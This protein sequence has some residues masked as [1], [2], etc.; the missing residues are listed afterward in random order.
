LAKSSCC[1]TTTIINT[2]K[3]D[4]NGINI[5]TYKGPLLL[6]CHFEN[7]YTCDDSEIGADF[8]TS[9]T[10]GRFGQAVLINGLD[11]LNYPSSGNINKNQGTIEFWIK[12]N[13]WDYENDKVDRTFFYINGSGNSENESL[14][15]S[16][17][18]SD[19]V[20]H[21]D[22]DT[23]PY[24]GA[25]RVWD[26]QKFNDELY[27]GIDIL[28]TVWK[29][30][31]TTDIWQVVT[32]LKNIDNDADAI[33]NLEVYDNQIWAATIN[34]GLNTQGIYNST[35]GINWSQNIEWSGLGTS[36]VWELQADGDYLFAMLS[37]HDI[38][39][40]AIL[41][42]YNGSD[43]EQ[44]FDFTSQG[45][46]RLFDLKRYNDTGGLSQLYLATG[47]GR[48]SGGV[49]CYIYNSSSNGTTWDVFK[50][51]SN[52]FNENCESVADLIVF[53]NN[54]FAVVNNGS[55]SDIGGGSIWEYDG[56]TWFHRINY[57][58]VFNSFHE[59][60]G[61]LY[62]SAWIDNIA[63]S[64]ELWKS[65]NGVDW[66]IVAD[67]IES[68]CDQIDEISSFQDRVYLGTHKGTEIHRS[69]EVGKGAG[70]TTFFTITDTK[71][72]T[73]RVKHEYDYTNKFTHI[74]TKWNLD[75]NGNNQMSLY[76]DNVL[77]DSIPNNNPA[78]SF[79]TLAD[80]MYIGSDNLG[81]NQA[82]AI[83]DELRIYNIQ[84]SEDE[85]NITY[86]SEIG[87]YYANITD[88]TDGIYTYIGYVK[89]SN[90]DENNTGPRTITFQ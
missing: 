33:M 23:G 38:N 54:L 48:S 66:Y 64:C 39:P 46:N 58:K 85:S 42:R 8:G 6:S 56:S 13:G 14:Q 18:F 37:R 72:D 63:N 81:N 1:E 34:F 62:V 84:K 80:T 44:V 10:T 15:I 75:N 67:S 24:V 61:E 52:D 73:F 31:T 43:W 28:G 60:D 19:I 32:E 4:W 88:N 40:G 25:D 76:M 26:L 69:A 74:A 35:N 20:L 30:N 79:G 3:I 17:D 2:F 45:I 89:D 29:L 57:T 78:I 27:A 77:V 5:T 22:L 55:S 53:N 12:P 50:N 51:F 86:R 65:G 7:S 21:Q 59:F 11:T 49:G 87:K 16:V 41:Q 47:I 90:G 71:N 9:F 68:A 70:Y 82:N 36:T 83:I